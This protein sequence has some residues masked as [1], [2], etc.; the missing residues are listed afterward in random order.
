MT[1]K[2]GSF[3][4]ASISLNTSPQMVAKY[5][6]FLETQLGLK[7]LNRTTRSQNLTEFG[8]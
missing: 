1:V 5:I 6:L 3:A 4:S 2:T 7:L 8:K